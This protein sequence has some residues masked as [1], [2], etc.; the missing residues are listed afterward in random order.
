MIIIVCQLYNT[1]TN[2]KVLPLE[3]AIKNCHDASN[4]NRGNSIKKRSLQVCQNNPVIATR[5]DIFIIR[6]SELN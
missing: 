4:R 6:C 1:E 5:C 2:L 3:K